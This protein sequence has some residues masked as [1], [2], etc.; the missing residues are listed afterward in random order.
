MIRY[1]NIV[2]D[3]IAIAFLIT[4]IVLVIELRKHVKSQTKEVCIEEGS[5]DILGNQVEKDLDNQC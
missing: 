3:L 1:Q 5:T 2:I 4:L